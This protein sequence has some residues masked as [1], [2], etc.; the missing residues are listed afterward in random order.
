MLQYDS[1][2][3][4]S[5]TTSFAK[6]SKKPNLNECVHNE[7]YGKPTEKT[8]NDQKAIPSENKTTESLLE[9]H[10]LQPLQYD[11]SN[12]GTGEVGG[13]Y[14]D[15][16]YIY[17]TPI[18]SL[19]PQCSAEQRKNN[20]RRRLISIFDDDDISFSSEI[21]GATINLE[22]QNVPESMGQNNENLTRF[23]NP[24]NL[25]ETSSETVETPSATPENSTDSS[26]KPSE[27]LE[28]PSDST[29]NPPD[30]P[31]NPSVS[32]GK[33]SDTSKSPSDSTGN[34]SDAPGS[35]KP[36][37]V[38]TTSN[39]SGKRKWDKRQ[40]C[41]Y[42]GKL[43]TQMPKHLERAHSNEK[44][45]KAFINLKPGDPKRISILNKLRNTGNYIHNTKVLETKCGTLIPQRRQQ[46]MKSPSKFVPCANCHQF[47]LKSRLSKHKRKCES[48]Q[49]SSTLN[50][51]QSVLSQ[52]KHM[53]PVT[54]HERYRQI[55]ETK[56]IGGMKE[57]D[58]AYY[59]ILS[60]D[61]ILE[62]GTELVEKYGGKDEHKNHIRGK[63][64]EVSRF[65]IEVKAVAVLIAKSETDQDKKE[66]LNK[67]SSLTDLCK[68]SC[69]VDL[70]VQA[71]KNLAQFDIATNTFK[72][73]DLAK[74]IGEDIKYCATICLKGAIKRKDDETKE[75]IKDFLFVLEKEWYTRI[76]SKALSTIYERN[77]NKE[78]QVPDPKDMEKLN[79]F[80]TQQ[81]DQMML[82]LAQSPNTSTYAQ[83]VKLALVCVIVF[84]RKRAGDAHKLLLET[85]HKKARG[86]IHQ[87]IFKSLSENEK[88]LVESF[89]RL[90]TKGKRGLKV[91]ILLTP[92]IEKMTE[93]LVKHRQ[94]CGVPPDNRYFFAIPKTSQSY[95]RG[96]DA[97]RWVRSKVKLERP[98]M[99]TSTKLRK[100]VATLAAVSGLPE[101]QVDQL[102]TFLGHSATTHKKYYRLPEATYQTAKVSQ[103]LLN[104]NSSNNI[105]TTESNSTQRPTHAHS[106]EDGFPND[107]VNFQRR[108]RTANPKPK[109]NRSTRQNDPD[110]HPN[111]EGSS[112]GPQ[113]PRSNPRNK[114]MPK[115]S[116]WTD[117]QRKAV[118]SEII[119]RFLGKVPGK[120]LALQAIAKH[121][122]LS[123]K[124]WLDI[125]NK[126]HSIIYVRKH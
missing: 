95:Y 110:Y 55:L 45:V 5:L 106:E 98:E 123:S 36:I 66:R 42:C 82:D 27:T 89:S 59:Q 113:R 12:S 29:R 101:S 63:L 120:E 68:V 76:N 46:E 7:F 15:H 81:R 35:Y 57:K 103:F 73:A 72:K 70:A 90:E 125:K 43:L 44:D 91:P 111:Q 124:T 38:A 19:K 115:R 109:S 116:S 126:V 17:P 39:S 100:E 34:P 105:Q 64:R 50:M 24:F 47:F 62:Y 122:C 71:T 112:N 54:D 87:R 20:V 28:N 75:G 51:R 16:D 58:D 11:T 48:N 9:F 23:S 114:T 96:S 10:T 74:R 94:E 97:I 18:N 40:S 117:E 41:F 52:A 84:N 13:P 102:A 69:N 67:L 25:L 60:D 33:P 85:Y 32:S 21:D 61:L 2:C 108:D 79:E 99:I 65:L 22:N 92:E 119:T 6:E 80:L 49:N 88:I 93:L 1:D 86:K 121:K 107:V 14:Q 31:E 118:K 104:V 8:Q 77:F 37:L 26:G 78:L 53:L 83:L 56:V 3:T 4:P 30:S